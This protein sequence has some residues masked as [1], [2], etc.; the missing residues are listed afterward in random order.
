MI[1][2]SSK[3][4]KKVIREVKDHVF[5]KT[6]SGIYNWTQQK[7]Q[8]AV[9]HNLPSMSWLSHWGSTTVEHAYASSKTDEFLGALY[10]FFASNKNI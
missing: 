5:A 1:S 4:W 9:D 6:M 3:R 2:Q 10:V 8:E 7:L